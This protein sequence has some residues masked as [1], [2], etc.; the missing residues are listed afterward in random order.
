MHHC[1]YSHRCHSDAKLFFF[2]VL[3]H[4]SLYFSIVVVMLA[5]LIPDILKPMSVI[6]GLSSS[7]DSTAAK[8]GFMSSPDY[9]AEAG[10]A[11]KPM[12]RCISS[13]S[14]NDY[15]STRSNDMS[16]EEACLRMAA[17]GRA[18]RKAGRHV[19]VGGKLVLSSRP[20]M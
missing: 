6:C 12:T 15:D 18:A 5:S 7:S 1:R 8:T 2:L 20:R 11:Y 4:V 3:T 14:T 10:L 17:H 9:I 19:L 16:D 13:T